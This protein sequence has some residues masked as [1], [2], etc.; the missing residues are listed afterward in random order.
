VSSRWRQFQDMVGV[1]YPIMQDGMGPSPTTHL[2]AAVSSAGGLG[3]VSCPS[4]T[5]T[6]EE[7]LRQGFRAAIETVAARTDRP[8]AVNVPVGRTASGELLL[9]SR[10][11]IDEA[12]TAKRDGGRVGE[13]LRAIVTSAGFAGEFGQQIR[14]SGLVHMHKVGSVKHARKAAEYGADVIIASGFEMGG[15]THGK[16][17]HTMVLAPQVIDA[18]DLPVVVS[19]GIADGRG[20][21]AVLAM[22]AAAAAMGTRFIATREH[23]WHDAYKQRIV[24]AKEWDDVV[25]Q[26][27]Y[28][29][30]RGL[31]NKGLEAM[32]QARESLSGEEFQAWEE[33]Q[34]RKAQ[35]DGDVENGLLVAGQVAAAVHDIP[36]VAELIGRIVTQARALLGEA[37]TAL[38]VPAIAGA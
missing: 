13:Q 5:N 3:T 14:A 34:I 38:D 37:A 18:L 22:G 15:H 11:C 26:G 10:V 21:A 9:V 20:L 23:E 7:F 29:P 28:A 12:I 17:V 19:G 16:A 31:L 4:I 32:P 30:I 1:Q 36:T 27:I 8:F 24:D 35:R 25:Y 6:S 33:E 2:A